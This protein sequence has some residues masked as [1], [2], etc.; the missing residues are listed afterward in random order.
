LVNTIADTL[1]ERGSRY[2]DFALHAEISQAFEDVAR[3]TPGWQR[4]SAAQKESLKL[5]WHKQA[6]ILNGDPNY[7]DSWVDIAGYSQLVVDILRKPMAAYRVEPLLEKVPAD[8]QTISGTVKLP[9]LPE[10]PVP[11]TDRF[12]PQFAAPPAPVS[13]P[14]PVAPPVPVA[15]TKAEGSE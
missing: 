3:N 4:L 14:S 7:D 1:A 6:R 12:R 8:G 9:N 15:V 2:G 13:P 11:A 5:Q 10:A